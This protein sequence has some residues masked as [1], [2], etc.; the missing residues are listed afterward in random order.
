[1]VLCNGF[2]TPY[3]ELVLFLYISISLLRK[4]YSML[5]VIYISTEKPCMMNVFR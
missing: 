3:Y 1:M 2:L 5:A 4:T